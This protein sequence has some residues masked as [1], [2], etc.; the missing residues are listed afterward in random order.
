MRDLGPAACVSA[1]RCT[2]ASDFASL[3]SWWPCH[4]FVSSPWFD[5]VKTPWAG[6]VLHGVRHTA[7]GLEDSWP[8]PEALRRLASWRLL[9]FFTVTAQLRVLVSVKMPASKGVRVGSVPSRGNHPP[10]AALAW[11]SHSF[12]CVGRQA[13]VSDRTRSTPPCRGPGGLCGRGSWWGLVTTV[14]GRA[15]EDAEAHGPLPGPAGLS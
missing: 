2:Q 12:S 14:T 15:W 5:P 13:R 1:E 8:R 7:C 10:W 11:R 9:C 4:M 3:R 6:S